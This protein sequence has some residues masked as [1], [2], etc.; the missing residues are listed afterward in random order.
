M[1][2]PTFA[3][4]DDVARL[5]RRIWYWPVVRGVLALVFGLFA[6]LLPDITPALLVQVFGAF[7]VV[8]GLVSLAD[9]LRRRGTRAGSANLGVGV[10]A[11]VFGAVLLLLPHLVLGV[12]LVMIALWA[13]AFGLLQLVVASVMRSRGGTTWL[14]SMVSGVLLVALAVVCLVSPSASIAVMS[15]IVGVFAC[16]I[17]AALLALGLR[18]RSMGR[19]GSPGPRRDGRVIEGE[20][21]EE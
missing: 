7:V 15:V 3:Q 17:G 20:I 21:V 16:V 10:V 1:A 13:L 8:D 18:L 4:P 9:G 2:F 5:A 11:V 19:Q 12:V 6:I 14:W